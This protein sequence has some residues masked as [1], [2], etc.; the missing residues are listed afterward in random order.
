MANFQR[1]KKVE[2][3]LYSKILIFVLF[4]IFCILL[5]GAIGMTRKAIEASKNRKNATEKLNELTQQKNLLE[6]QNN[7][8]K[9][10][11]GIEENIRD[12][13]RVV[14]NGEG[15]VII[16]DDQNKTDESEKIQNGGGFWKLLK[17]IF[18]RP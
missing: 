15:L 7:D 17:K 6:K 9:T 13:Y 12:K 16:V 1:K 8:L 5:V 2:K 11:K 3:I 4:I 10:E 14:K 18:S